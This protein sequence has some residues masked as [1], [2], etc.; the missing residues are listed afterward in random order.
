MGP[1]RIR[2]GVRHGED[3]TI[4]VIHMYFAKYDLIR[5]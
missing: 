2:P 1:E 4:I 3:I 5:L